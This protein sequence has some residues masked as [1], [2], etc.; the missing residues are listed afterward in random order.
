MALGFA[1]DRSGRV[2]RDPLVRLLM[3]GVETEA[4]QRRRRDVL[5][6]PGL[7]GRRDL[8]LH[9]GVSAML[10]GL[11]GSGVAEAAG[12]QKE[13]SDARGKEAGRGSG[14]S[15]TDLAADYAGIELA[16]VLLKADEKQS[17]RLLKVIAGKF[18]G[19]DYL[20]DCSD[21]PEGLTHSEF[22]QSYGSVS[23]SR[24]ADYAQK[25]RDRV[26]AAPGWKRLRDAVSRGDST[27]SE[28]SVADPS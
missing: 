18:R 20:P 5:G 28:P 12:L 21:L 14:F 16:E 27:S 25:V 17:R 19:K 1:F 13:I 3:R 7:R 11:S 24:F 22:V 2:A 6:R 26:R 9:F 8:L 4:E 23:D 15:F 10:T